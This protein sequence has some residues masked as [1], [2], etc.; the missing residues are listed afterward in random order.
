[1][2]LGGVDGECK[3]IFVACPLTPRAIEFSAFLGFPR[4]IEV[5]RGWKRK[6]HDPAEY[7]A[8]LDAPD[9]VPYATS[10]WWVEDIL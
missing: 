9:R 2:A 5:A 3:R 6:R 7:G 1:M 10:R 8:R 4:P